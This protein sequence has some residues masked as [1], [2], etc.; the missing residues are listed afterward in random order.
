VPGLG[1]VHCKFCKDRGWKWCPR[2]KKEMRKLEEGVP[3][4]SV[5]DECKLCGGT[6]RVDCKAC[7]NRPAE[8]WL[9]EERVRQAKWLAERR[10]IDALAK[11]RLMH[12]ASPHF[13]LMFDI[14]R[15][16]VGRRTL[17]QHHLLHLYLDRLEALYERFKKVMACSDGD[18]HPPFRIFIWNSATDQARVSPR[19]TGLGGSGGT[20]SKLLGSRP[21]F[22]VA[23]GRGTRNDRDLHR[24]VVHNV[25]HLLLSNISP[26]VWIGKRKAGW[27]DAGVAHYFEFLLDG[28]CTN[29]CYTEQNTMVGFRGGKWRAYIRSKVALGAALPS[30]PSFYN[31]LID[32]LT[33]LEHALSFSYVEFLLNVYGG[34]KMKSLVRGI[35]QKRPQRE[36]FRRVYGFGILEL[37]KKWREHVL[38]TYPT[39]E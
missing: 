28:R 36:V 34:A 29:F 1:K 33:P 26:C 16:K 2:H 39:R 11:H 20:G 13:Q 5:R 17:D 3:F 4:C 38:K 37:E 32:E 23:K 8:E 10:K 7:K 25:A 9:R 15:M 22:T 24:C 19:I 6:L 12:A 18:F 21:A 35:M 27:L 31:K 30:F 14:P